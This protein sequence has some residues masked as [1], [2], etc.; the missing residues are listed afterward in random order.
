MFFKSSANNADYNANAENIP[1]KFVDVP[2][3]V[4]GLEMTT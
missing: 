4:K 1:R 3:S 2:G